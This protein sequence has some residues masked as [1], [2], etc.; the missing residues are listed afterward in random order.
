MVGRG[1][2]QRLR[3][4]QAT[5]WALQHW[6]P[7]PVELVLAPQPRTVAQLPG[8]LSKKRG[9]AGRGAPAPPLRAAASSP[10][11]RGVA[12]QQALHLRQVVV[13][14]GPGAARQQVRDGVGGGARRQRRVQ[15]RGHAVRGVVGQVAAHNAVA[16]GA[17]RAGATAAAGAVKPRRRASVVEICGAGGVGG[18]GATRVGHMPGVRALRALAGRGAGGAGRQ[19]A[20]A[21]ALHPAH[22]GETRPALHPRTQ[23]CTAQE[24]E[25]QA[26][27]GCQL[28]LRLQLPKC[29]SQAHNRARHTRAQ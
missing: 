6:S 24:A 22:P 8:R 2:R 7:R 18:K 12:R 26:K 4:P 23:C 11:L 15:Q 29:R 1:C 16:H 21:A 27:P 17:A 25:R 5:A 10:H 19:A 3:C 20:A 14:L 28:I 9:Q 13:Q